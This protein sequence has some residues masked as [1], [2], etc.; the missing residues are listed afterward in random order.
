MAHETWNTCPF[1][2]RKWMN[3]EPI[4]G[5]VHRT[6]ACAHCFDFDD[7]KQDEKVEKRLRDKDRAGVP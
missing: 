6:K 5:V 4:P 3:A 2:G 1:C 7:H